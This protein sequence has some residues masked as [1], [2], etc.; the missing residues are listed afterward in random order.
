MRC[1][2]DADEF[3]AD[4]GEEG[5]VIGFRV[6]LGS[7]FGFRKKIMCAER[8]DSHRLEPRPPIRDCAVLV[9]GT[10]MEKQLIGGPMGVTID[11]AARRAIW[12]DGNEMEAIF[13]MGIATEGNLETLR[14]AQASRS[15]SP[16]GEPF[17]RLPA[18]GGSRTAQPHVLVMLA[19]VQ[20]KPAGCWEPTDLSEFTILVA[21]ARARAK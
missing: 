15:N 13:A 10:L 17:A 18:G 5:G 19:R 21:A 20:G 11:R 2:G 7:G 4:A 14:A 9:M 16:L 3:D 12:L 8:N 6:S 1:D